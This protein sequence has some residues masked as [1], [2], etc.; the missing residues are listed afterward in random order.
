M[1]NHIF[2][3]FYKAICDETKCLNGGE[4]KETGNDKYICKCPDG[5]NGPNCECKLERFFVY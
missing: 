4:C 2:F 3:K 5:F 1:L